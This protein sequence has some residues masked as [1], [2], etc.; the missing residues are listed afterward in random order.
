M[1]KKLL[2]TL[3]AITSFA[4]YYV[5][6]NPLYS[7]IGNIWQPE[8]GVTLLRAQNSEYEKTLTKAESL[9][10]E[11]KDLRTKYDAVS[12]EVKEKM[13]LM[14]PAKKDI[15]PVR[16]VSEVNSIANQEGLVISDLSYGEG[17]VTT[18]NRG[19]YVL[20]FSIKTTYTKFKELMQ[21][22]ETSLRLFTIQS[23]QFIAP[24]AD[25]NITTFQVKMETYYIK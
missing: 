12:P 8:A 22:Y 24:E 19:S 9:I 7:G 1:S 3:L 6:I 11:S 4:L 16:L 18:G 14:V 20:S 10:S 5:V 21:S 15:D 25:S 17:S 2:Y 23:V 13:K